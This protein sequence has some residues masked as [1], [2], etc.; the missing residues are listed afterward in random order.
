[1][2]KNI[3]FV[4]YLIDLNEN[5]RP[6]KIEEYWEL[7][8]KLAGTGIKCILYIS[9]SYRLIYENKIKLFY[10]NIILETLDFTDLWINKQIQELQI[11]YQ[12]INIPKTD[13]PNKDTIKYH[14]II[15][16]KVEIIYL[17][18]KKYI[19]YN[20]YF[21][22][23]IGI[24]HIIKNE[25]LIYNKLMSIN[26]YKKNETEIQWDLIAPSTNWCKINKKDIN[27]DL[28]W[29]Q[30]YW[31]YLGGIIIISSNFIN[32]FWDTYKFFLLE[33]CLKKK[34]IVWEVNIWALIETLNQNWKIKTYTSD[35]NDTMIL[36]IPNL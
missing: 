15:N 25:E 24:F 6:R 20:Y 4:S 14:I 2:D 7:F 35:H 23:D 11:N 33:E 27:N 31:R 30:I 1:M 32:I 34:R 19:G 26:Q 21:F 13:N 8:K 17:S 22:I 18:S 9:K 28:Y 10:P 5:N 36:N 3:L 16:S 29:K 12:D